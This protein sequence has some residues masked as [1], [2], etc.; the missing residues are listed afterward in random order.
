MA[1]RKE[2][3]DV[4]MKLYNKKMQSATLT[5]W[6]KEGKVRITVL[7]NG[8]YDY[9]LEDFIAVVKSPEYLMKANA[10]KEKP[11]D[12]IGRTKGHLL[13]KSIVPKEE[14]QSKYNGTLMYCDCLACGNKN[15]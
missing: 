11:I 9:N 1:T 3:D 13:I 7:D 12:Y 15:I 10:H 4:F 14:Y 5:R 8:R 2:I 6:V